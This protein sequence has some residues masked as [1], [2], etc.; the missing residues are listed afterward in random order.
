ME[1][2]P[3]ATG[4][5]MFSKNFFLLLLF[6]LLLTDLNCQAIILATESRGLPSMFEAFMF[7]VRDNV[8]NVH[9]GGALQGRGL[10]GMCGPCL[11][12]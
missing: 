7:D 1:T 3:V 9:R 10:P 4:D 11:N 12:V 6:F 2:D 5:R 8:Y